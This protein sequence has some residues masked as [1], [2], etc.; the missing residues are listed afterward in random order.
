MKNKRLSDSATDDIDLKARAVAMVAFFTGRLPECGIF[1]FD[2]QGCLLAAS[3]ADEIPEK[4]RREILQNAS[5]EARP[6]SITDDRRHFLSLSLDDCLV[7]CAPENQSPFFHSLFAL[8]AELWVSEGR[9]GYLEKKLTIQKNQYQ[10]RIAVL[11]NKRQEMLE[12]AQRSYHLIQRQQEDYSQRLQAEIEERTR[13]L[14]KSKQA[15]EAANVA[16]SQFLAAMS[17]EIRTPMNGIIGFTDML[18]ASDLDDEQRDNAMTIKRS[19]DALLAIINDILDFSKV[20]AG[21]MTLECIDF[22]PEITAYDICNL[23]RPRV[24]GK[25]IEVLCRIDDRLPANVQGDPG[26]FRQ[27]LLNLM[28]NAT[29]FTE[30]GEIELAIMVESENETNIGLHCSVRDTGIGMTPEHFSTI[31]EEFSQADASITRKYGGS[32][33]GL[34]I[35]KR[36]AHLMGGDLWVESQLGAG[37]TFHFTAAMRK[38]PLAQR[39]AVDQT[40][41]RD[42]RVLIVDDNRNSIEI[43]RSS[44]TPGGIITVA[45]QDPRLAVGE[46]Q[47]AAQAG[48]PYDL[49]IL[50]ILMPELDGFALAMAIRAL[51]G[52]AGTIPL[53]AYTLASEKIATRCQEVGFNAF[54]NKPS[55]RKIL[56]RTV[57]RLLDRQAPPPVASVSGQRLVTQ[58][59]VREELKQS[60]R[61]LL[62]EDNPI[63]QKLAMAMLGKAGYLVTLA[64]NGRQAVKMYCQ[65]P[66][67]FDII[68]MDVQMPELDGLEATRQIRARGFTAVPVV[69]MTANSMTGDREECLAAGM[70]DY[71]SKPIKREVVFQALDR[72]L[73][74]AGGTSAM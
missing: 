70:N 24:S 54:L 33:L 58:Y 15:A 12:E 60:V 66:R 68:L 25:R 74:I 34:A 3:G 51:P 37:A 9:R 64:E 20:E 36:I 29:K 57:L 35:S 41:L 44:L 69:A 56:L 13:E 43:L 32:G 30:K 4:P 16:K 31:F 48:T 59:L 40:N 10:R 73:Y 46:L 38:S 49:A 42:K 14:H 7:V 45:V 22:D 1:C 26:R 72:W 2:G 11:E 55:Q 47:K 6:L 52:D 19:G 8:T 67:R 39:P 63:N 65:D 50:D 5:S 23:I 21:K 61:I 53:L 28:G 18:L 17:H 27:V 71:I 62:A